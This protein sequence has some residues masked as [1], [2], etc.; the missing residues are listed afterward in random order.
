LSTQYRIFEIVEREEA[1]LGCN[2]PNETSREMVYGL[3]VEVQMPDYGQA[4]LEY[5]RMTKPESYTQ[6]EFEHVAL[7]SLKSQCATA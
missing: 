4:K 6:S 2:D 1:R 3:A 7:S 5:L